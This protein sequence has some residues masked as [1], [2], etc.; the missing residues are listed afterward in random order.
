MTMKTNIQR[1]AQGNITIQMQGGLDY[2]YCLP[3][4]EQLDRIVKEY[5]TTQITIDMAGMDFV[6][7]SGISHFVET[8]KNIHSKNSGKINLS[9]VNQEF[10]RVFRLFD[11]NDYQVTL[12]FVDMDST[13][14]SELNTVFGNRTRT[15][16]N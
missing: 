11:F 16:E 15:F 8:I 5:P 10:Q 2:E 1:D 12:D 9:N 13:E 6:G 3:L 4:R 7:S 14:T